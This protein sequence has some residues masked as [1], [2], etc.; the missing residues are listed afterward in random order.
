MGALWLR[1]GLWV[2]ARGR[3]GYPEGCAHARATGNGSDSW[4]GTIF[5]RSFPSLYYLCFNP[6]NV[7]RY[8]FTESV[9]RIQG[10]SSV[11]SQRW[12]TGNALSGP[13]GVV[14]LMMDYG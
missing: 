4:T 9:K 2:T 1:I 8:I 6:L 14:Q 5:D 12:Y 13:R 10:L 3:S 11:S 7:K